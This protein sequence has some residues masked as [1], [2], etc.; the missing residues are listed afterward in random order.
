MAPAATSAMPAVR[1]MEEVAL[2][3]ERPA[4]RAKGTVSPS[5]TPMMMSRTISPAVKCFSVWRFRRP[6]FSGSRLSLCSAPAISAILCLCF[7]V[8]ID[9]AIQTKPISVHKTVVVVPMHMNEYIQ[10]KHL[11]VSFPFNLRFIGVISI[12]STNYNKLIER[13]VVSTRRVN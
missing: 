5:E 3:P 11:A 8:R 4:A 13:V 10:L 6:C 12:I 9:I 7:K 1:T 2:A